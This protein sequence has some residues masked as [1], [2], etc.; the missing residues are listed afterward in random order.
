[1]VEAFVIVMLH[2]VVFKL[3][4]VCSDVMDVRLD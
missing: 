3:R 4:Y 2:Y 1:M